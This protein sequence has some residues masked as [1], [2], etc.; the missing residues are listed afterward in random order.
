MWLT[1]EYLETFWLLYVHLFLHKSI[2]KHSFQIHLM[3]APPHLH[4]ECKDGSNGRVP[5]NWCKILIIVDPLNLWESLGHTSVILLLHTPI[6]NFLYLVDPSRYNHWFVDRSW[7]NLPCTVLDN[8]VIILYH[9]INPNWL[10]HYLLKG[11][12]LCHN[13]LAHKRHVS[14]KLVCRMSLSA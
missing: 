10:L 12:W 4:W 6:N 9:C 8:G 3:N 2:E 1:V 5:C 14:S 11:R 13:T 7:D